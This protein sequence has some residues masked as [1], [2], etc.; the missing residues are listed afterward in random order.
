MRTIKKRKQINTGS[1]VNR[2]TYKQ[3]KKKSTNRKFNKQE[4]HKSNG[5]WG[6]KRFGRKVSGVFCDGVIGN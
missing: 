6:R 5:S 1:H 3:K 2:M 4:V